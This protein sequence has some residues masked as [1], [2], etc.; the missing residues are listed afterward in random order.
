MKRWRAILLV[1][2]GGALVL[3]QALHAQPSPE[4]ARLV[5][6]VAAIE[7][8]TGTLDA[9]EALTRLQQ[10][11]ASITTNDIPSLG[12][13]QHPHWFLV[14]IDTGSGGEHFL[15]AGRPHS[16]Y[17]DLYLLDQFGQL[18]DHQQHGDMRMWA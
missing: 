18:I 12:F 7:D 1:M 16:D 17:L 13:Q 9:G 14:P 6:P 5:L 8:T 2:L 15:V 3:P 10:G 4:S 11:G